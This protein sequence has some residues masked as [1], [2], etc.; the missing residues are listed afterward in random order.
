MCIRDRFRSVDERHAVSCSVKASTGHLYPLERSFV[1]IH[2]PTLVLRFEDVAAVEFE[3]FSGSPAGAA[4]EEG[5]FFEATLR[6][7]SKRALSSPRERARGR[8]FSSL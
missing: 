4:T 2:K 5:A 8:L 7:P 1:F 6:R 3:R